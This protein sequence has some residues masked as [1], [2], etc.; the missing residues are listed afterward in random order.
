MYPL[1]KLIS[2]TDL[3]IVDHYVVRC[4]GSLHI[5]N[6]T[7]LARLLKQIP[8]EILAHQLR[9]S[10]SSITEWSIV[11]NLLSDFDFRAKEIQDNI[12]PFKPSASKV[13][14]LNRSDSIHKAKPVKTRPQAWMYI[15]RY[16]KN[17]SAHDQLNKIP[18]ISGKTHNSGQ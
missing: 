12:A 9:E 16:L 2:V 18:L 13:A 5:V 3:G 1:L 17:C 7:W 15:D 10:L 6:K 11:N 14:P 4:Q 8:V